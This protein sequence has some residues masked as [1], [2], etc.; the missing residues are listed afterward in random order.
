MSELLA[1]LVD[2]GDTV[3]DAGANVGYMTLLAALAAGPAGKVLSFEPHPELFE[4]ARR[5]VGAA[6][7][8]FRMAEVELREA[9]LGKETGR[10]QL[11]M[12]EGFELNDGIARIAPDDDAGRSVSVVIEALDDV[13]QEQTASV[14]K[15]DVEGFEYRALQGAA[16]T[17]A[18]RRVRHVIFE[19]HRI[20]RSEARRWLEDL[21]YRL[22][23]VG[24]SLN[25]L[26]L[27][28]V[29]AFRAVHHQEAPNFIATVDPDGLA[30]RCA[31]GGWSVLRQRIA[32][33]ARLRRHR[34]TSEFIRFVLG[35]RGAQS[36]VT[37]NERKFLAQ[38]AAGRSAV[39]EVGVHEG[40][41]S[42]LLRCAMRRDGTLYLVDP[43]KNAVRLETLLGFS[44]AEYVARR[45][46][47]ACDGEVKFIK[48]YSAAVADRLFGKL[49]ADL[50]FI[51]AAHDYES[52]T[53]DFLKWSRLLKRNGIM[54]FHD[55]RPCGARPDLPASA[56]PVRLM[57]DIRLG[58]HGPWEVCGEA[59]SVTA[60]RRV[61]VWTA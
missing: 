9:A 52:V 15:L 40:A 57:E 12:P 34:Y 38:L 46:L 4:V 48:E 27:Y 20:E 23:A 43:Y 21:G 25:R 28:P 47:R 7:E 41:T 51:D 60:V 18:A 44:F 24:W 56:G 14:L 49:E 31:A 8:R 2:P 54:A 26:M 33:R 1:R 61:A 50:V 53:E 13:L 42:E 16:R 6:R 55:S 10:G 22:Y 39:V 17:L 5:N 58:R 37:A 36:S 3:I 29:E 19:D 11:L 30:L 35:L 45:T 59:D 32:R